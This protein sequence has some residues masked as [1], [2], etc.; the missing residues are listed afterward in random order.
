MRHGA[1]INIRWPFGLDNIVTDTFVGF[2]GLIDQKRIG[3]QSVNFARKGRGHTD[4]L[5]LNDGLECFRVGDFAA[6]QM[7]E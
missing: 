5:R 1:S 6:R 7:F 2:A 3:K 4:M